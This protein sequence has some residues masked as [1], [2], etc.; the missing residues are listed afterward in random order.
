MSLL[1]RLKTA[2]LCIGLL[3]TSTPVAAQSVDHPFQL[4]RDGE[5]W[6]MAL[7]TAVVLIVGVVVMLVIQGRK[8][9]QEGRGDE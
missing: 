3:L 7:G 6:L 8:R 4:P 9:R 5:T 2:L 1:D